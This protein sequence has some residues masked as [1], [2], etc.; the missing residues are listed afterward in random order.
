MGCRVNP[1][2]GTTAFPGKAAAARLAALAF[3]SLGG[4]VAQ[5]PRGREREG[6]R[7]SEREREGDLCSN[8]EQAGKIST[9]KGG[10]RGTSSG[11]FR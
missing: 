10:P 6:A 3:P 11:T 7:G 4:G 1:T 2:T 9:P 5:T 8:F